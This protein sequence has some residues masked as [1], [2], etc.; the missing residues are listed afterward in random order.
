MV[1]TPVAP[2]VQVDDTVAEP[3]RPSVAFA[4]IGSQAPKFKSVTFMVQDALMLAVTAMSDVDKVAQVLTLR[5]LMPK[6]IADMIVK[7]SCLWFRFVF[8]LF[9]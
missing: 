5:L 2:D 3:V 6:S 1:T 9:T 8:T 4:T 7:L